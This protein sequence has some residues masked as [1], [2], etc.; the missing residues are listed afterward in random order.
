M[1]GRNKVPDRGITK[2]VSL[3]LTPITADYRKQ[4][5]DFDL[6]NCT[7]RLKLDASGYV[8]GML[9]IARLDQSSGAN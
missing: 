5:T 4:K 8:P 2:L 3:P 7:I 1:F 9:P 6:N